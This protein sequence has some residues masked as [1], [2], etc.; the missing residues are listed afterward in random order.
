MLIFPCSGHLLG[1]LYW[2]IVWKALIL[3]F[4]TEVILLLQTLIKMQL[5]LFEWVVM[6]VAGQCSWASCIQ[7]LGTWIAILHNR[8]KIVE[9]SCCRAVGWM[10]S[11]QADSWR[12]ERVVVL[13]LCCSSQVP[14]D[15]ARLSWELLHL[16]GSHRLF[17]FPSLLY[18]CCFATSYIYYYYAVLP[19]LCFFVVCTY[20]W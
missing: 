6:V 19:V 4:K 18:P 5:Y 1:E 11:G 17:F 20:F 12:L 13:V 14:A 7:S 8:C 15:T 10:Q 2:T 3:E 16:I 9:V